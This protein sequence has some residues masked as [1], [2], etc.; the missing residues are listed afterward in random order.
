[1]T[2]LAANVLLSDGKKLVG[3]RLA[4]QSQPPSLYWLRG[5]SQFPNAVIVASEPLFDGP[6]TAF[7]ASSL[8]TVTADCDLQFYSLS[9]R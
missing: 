2:P 3:A 1:N 5:V 7:E 4:F 8:F 6:W 9:R